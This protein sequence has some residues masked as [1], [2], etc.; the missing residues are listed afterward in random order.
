MTPVCDT[1]RM[2]SLIWRPAAGRRTGARPRGRKLTTLTYGPC[3]SQGQLNTEVVHVITGGSSYVG[4]HRLQ[5]TG[6]CMRTNVGHTLSQKEMPCKG[7]STQQ[8]VGVP[9]T[10]PRASSNVHQR[11]SDFWIL[12]D[13]SNIFSIANQSFVTPSTARVHRERG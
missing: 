1:E 2:R 8:G 6:F 5:R 4:C 11:S 9:E 3:H 10:L 13:C 12:A 7:I